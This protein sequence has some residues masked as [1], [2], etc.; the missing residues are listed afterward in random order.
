[1][2]TLSLG[3]PIRRYS[4]TGIRGSFGSVC[5]VRHASARCPASP[6]NRKVV[7]LGGPSEAQR[8]R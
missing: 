8:R 5:D 4:P 7:H 2:M 6:V 3:L 1:M